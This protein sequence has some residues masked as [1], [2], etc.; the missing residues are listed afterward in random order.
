MLLI[1]TQSEAEALTIP[2]INQEW[3]N[4]TSR[5]LFIAFGFHISTLTMI[6]FRKYVLFPY[7]FSIIFINIL[8]GTKT[9]FIL[10]YLI[11]AVCFSSSGDILG[12]SLKYVCPFSL[13]TNSHCHRWLFWLMEGKIG[14]L[15]GMC[16]IQTSYSPTWDWHICDNYTSRQT[17]VLST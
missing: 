14:H 3:W 13:D 5:G 7:L 1:S 15:S 17:N 9:I 8:F 16:A 6:S 2:W 11:G 4:F 10:I 12:L